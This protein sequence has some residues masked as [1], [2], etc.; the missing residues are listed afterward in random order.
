MDRVLVV[1]DDDGVL[2]SIN[3]ILDKSYILMIYCSQSVGSMRQS[4]NPIPT[5]LLNIR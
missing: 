3:D 1:D 5:E 2:T 4:I